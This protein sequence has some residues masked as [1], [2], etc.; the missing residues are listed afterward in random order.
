MIVREREIDIYRKRKRALS[1][2]AD[3]KSERNF[4]ET[5]SFQLRIDE[6]EI[7]H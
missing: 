3:I 2:H 7:Y 6:A 4:M 1:R 5:D